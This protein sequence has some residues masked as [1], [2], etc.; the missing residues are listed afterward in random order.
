MT[1]AGP[2]AYHRFMGRWSRLVA[3]AFVPWLGVPPGGRWLDVGC[4]TGALSAAVIA[5]ASP[6]EVFGLDAEPDLVAFARASLPAPA[7]RFLEGDAMTLPE[8][9][10]DFDAT[11]SGLAINQF[12]DTPAG[13]AE[14]A[15][16]TRPGG[17][18]AAYVW[19]FARMGML[20]GMFDQAVALDPVAA[21]VDP[22]S[23]F[24][25]AGEEPLVGLWRAA[26]LREVSARPFDVVT[27]FADF[28][29]YWQ[30]FLSGRGRVS[31][32]V[33]SLPE[34]RRAELRERVR[35]ALPRGPDG[36]IALPALAWAVKGRRREQ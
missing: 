28:D 29:D 34:E 21:D 10:R 23:R 20:Q 7:G 32:Y 24:E 22:S 27:R 9:L 35:A 5:R 17:I 3:D 13:I 11:V 14:M 16:V 26:G 8:E 25:V 19:D 1:H 31:G 30:P 6:A 12:E 4:G 33:T 15:R 36:S 2:E 18:V